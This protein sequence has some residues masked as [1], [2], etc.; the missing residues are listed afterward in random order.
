VVFK[1]SDSAQAPVDAVAPIRLQASAGATPVV[2]ETEKSLT[3]IP[4]KLQMIVAADPGGDAYFLPPPDLS[5][6]TA[7]QQLPTQW[8]VK[9]FA[10]AG[11][12]ALQLM[13]GVGLS[14]GRQQRYRSG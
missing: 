14:P 11:A 7:I 1:L 3:I 12:T 10:P 9:S 8:T 6:L 2:F 4:A 13:P 5:S